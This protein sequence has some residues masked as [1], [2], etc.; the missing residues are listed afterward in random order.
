MISCVGAYPV[1]RHQRNR[2]KLQ[3]RYEKRHEASSECETL[4]NTGA[5]RWRGIRACH[6][7]W[8]LKPRL[9]GLRPR[10]PPAW[11]AGMRHRDIR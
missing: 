2:A 6:G 8:R 1:S 10:S 4:H 3:G 5:E 11:A 7:G 9:Y